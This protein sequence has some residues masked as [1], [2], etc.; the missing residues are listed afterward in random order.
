[1]VVVDIKT[2][3]RISL[4][5]VS[6]KYR[7]AEG[8]PGSV[9]EPGSWG[10]RSF[11]GTCD[12]V[13]TE[14]LL[15]QGRSALYYVQ[16]LSAI[17]AAEDGAGAGHLCERVGAGARGDGV[18]SPGLCGDA[19]ACA[20]SNERAQAG[21]ALERAAKTEATSVAETAEARKACVRGADAVAVC[22]DG[23]AA[24]GV[25]AGAVLRFQCV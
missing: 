18:S 25:L 7:E 6:W 24:A 21:N 2:V 15:W 4:R 14:A 8:A 5:Y 1:M 23:R 10:G 20:S 19:G 12:A 16:L 3:E 13:W 11:R 9:F 17:A 22:G